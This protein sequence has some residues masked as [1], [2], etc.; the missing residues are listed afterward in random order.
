[1]SVV[2]DAVTG[3]QLFLAQHPPT[4][5]LNVDSL[6]VVQTPAP[7]TA[8]APPP[9]LPTYPTTAPNTP[10]PVTALTVEGPPTPTPLP[11]IERVPPT[12]TPQ[13]MT[14]YPTRDDLPACPA[15]ATPTAVQP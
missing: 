8:V 7:G 6:P 10:L 15:F 14:R 9:T 3:Q 1:M 11:T 4:S 12:V 2:L 13:A 5:E